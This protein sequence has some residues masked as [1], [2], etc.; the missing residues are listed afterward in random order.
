MIVLANGQI[1]IHRRAY[2]LSNARKWVAEGSISQR[3]KELI[4]NFLRDCELGRTVKNRAKKELGE[5]RLTKLAN[6][7]LNLAKW[8]EKDFD[9][10][11]KD[12]IV[13]LA[14]NIGLSICCVCKQQK[15]S[16]CGWLE[17]SEK[18]KYMVKNHSI[19]VKNG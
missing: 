9:K 7:L 4:L 15:P 13:N 1:D 2:V 16:L 5:S 3:N 10:A 18:F 12:D 14:F 19:M 17:V 6:T 8:L 11:V